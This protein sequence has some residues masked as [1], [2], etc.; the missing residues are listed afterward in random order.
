MVFICHLA[1]NLVLPGLKVN[2]FA[3]NRID[4]N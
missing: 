2:G 1:E 4:H 3:D